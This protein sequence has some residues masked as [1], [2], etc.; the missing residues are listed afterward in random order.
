MKRYLTIL[1]LLITSISFAQ[2]KYVLKVQGQPGVYNM[3]KVGDSLIYYVGGTRLA[4]SV[5]S[6]T[7]L[8][9][10][11][12]K[13]ESNSLLNGKLAIADTSTMLSPYQRIAN[14]FN[15][16]LADALYKPIGYVPTWSEVSGKPALVM[17]ADT[18]S[19][20]SPYAKVSVVSGK[21]NISDT[22]S[23]LNPYLKTAIAASQY[24]TIANLNLKANDNAVAHLAGSET[25]TGAKTFSKAANSAVTVVQPSPLS[26]FYISQIVLVNGTSVFGANDRTY[27]IVNNGVSSTASE[28]YIQYWN[29]IGYQRI[30]TIDS[31]KNT[32]FFGNLNLGTITN[33]TGNFVTRNSST[34]TL[35]ERT[36][37]QTQTDLGVQTKAQADALYL[38]LT[39]TAVSATKLATARTINGVSFDGTSNITVAD[40]TKEPAFTKNTAFN[41]NFDTLA[42]T[43]MEG[44]RAI[45]SINILNTRLKNIDASQIKTGKLDTARIPIT[46][47]NAQKGVTSNSV[48]G[49]LTFSLDSAYIK[50]SIFKQDATNTKLGLGAA[51]NNSTGTDNT[52]IGAYSGESGITG[53][54]RTSTGYNSNRKAKGNDNTAGG[55]YSNSEL[56]IGNDNTATGTNSGANYMFPGIDSLEKTT[57]IGSETGTTKN[58]ISNSTAIGFGATVNSS[59]QVVLGNKGVFETILRG[60]VTI[61]IIKPSAILVSTGTTFQFS[62]DTTNFFH[63]YSLANDAT[64]A[65]PTGNQKTDG[66]VLRIYIHNDATHANTL[67]W[68]SSFIASA[69]LP[70]PTTTAAN[71]GTYCEFFWDVVIDKWLLTKVIKNL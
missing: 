53:S 26:P 4:I 24:A 13:T 12:N 11:Y 35:T 34:G 45:D 8:S 10:Y 2:Q 56:I 68:G 71:Y 38:P 61:P 18:A 52:D 65:N 23:M 19:M 55:A 9:N 36:L 33:A 22:A 32:T 42:N 67:S 21:V 49:V 30:L 48:N 57:F 5:G 64:I 43:V 51:G 31:A 15:K 3:T 59:N 29:G 63:V 14:A 1:F 47:I 40:A 25:F 44:K 46:P 27:Q 39:G 62:T 20:L 16:A 37:A 66:Q 54:K 7:D 17:V 60:K 69:D 6:V 58:N 41:K 28:F 50:D 70:L